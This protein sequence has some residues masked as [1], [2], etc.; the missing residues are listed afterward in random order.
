MLTEVAHTIEE[1]GLLKGRGP[2]IVGVSGGMDSVALLHCLVGL[3]YPVVCAHFDH[4]LRPSSGAEKELVETAARRLDAPFETGSGD[5]LDFA[6]KAGL[7]VEAA[8]RRLRYRFLFDL[9][10]RAGARSVATAHTADD[11]VET[12]LMHFLRGSGL[13]GLRGMLPETILS[14]FDSRIPLARPMLGVWREQI[15]AFRTATGFDFVEDDS[16]L[17]PAYFRNRVRHEII[18]YLARSN[19][20]LPETLLRSAQALAADDDALEWAAREAW[21]DA[22]RSRSEEWVEFRFP[23]I[24]SLPAGLRVRLLRRAIGLLRGGIEEIDYESA[25]RAHR[26][27]DAPRSTAVCD[28]IGGL[29]LIR[30]HDRLWVAAGAEDLPTDAWP[31][32]AGAGEIGPSAGQLD[33]AGDWILALE[34]DRGERAEPSRFEIVLDPAALDF[35]LTVRGR[36]PGDR[37]SAS[38]M[39]GRSKRL[40]DAM[41]DWKIPRRLR[42]RWP[43]LV[44]GGRII[45]VPGYR[46]GEGVAAGP[47]TAGPLR[48]KLFRR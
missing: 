13:R 6:E 20:N 4:R 36:L 48:L 38:G 26:L 33:L 45:W 46:P 12:V 7:G 19:P 2:V 37:F 9:A 3:G 23:I 15:A 40:S 28:L 29:K 32:I 5:V 41:I 43:I 34:P 14:E 1:K 11:Q 47:D 39:G 30:E 27:I 21:D 22:L 18:P 16:N 31:Q 42:K 44:S 35:P 10:R 17:D 24:A 8:A 25:R